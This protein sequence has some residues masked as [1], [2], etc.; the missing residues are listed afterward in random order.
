MGK[1]QIHPKILK[2]LVIVIAVMAEMPLQCHM[3]DRNSAWGL[4]VWGGSY[5]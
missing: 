3:E 5:T 4:V 2:A 1:K